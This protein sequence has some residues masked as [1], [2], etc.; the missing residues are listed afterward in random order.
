MS[1]L[2]TV[3]TLQRSLYTESALSK[4]SIRHDMYQHFD[5]TCF[6]HVEARISLKLEA[7]VPPKRNQLYDLN[8][9]EISHYFFWEGNRLGLD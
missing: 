7:T 5:G 8:E 9:S 4:G 2:V 6:L 1:S 3:V